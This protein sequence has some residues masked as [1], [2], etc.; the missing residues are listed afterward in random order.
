MGW[1]N[2]KFLKEIPKTDLHVHLDGSLRL[3][4]LIELAKEQ[5]VELPSYTE[6]G[7]RELVFKP[8]Y[9]NLDEYL[10]GFNY[11][12][13]VMRD[14]QSIQRISY[15]LAYDCFEEG[16]RYIEVRFAPQLLMNDLL[17]FED[18]VKAVDDGLR[19]ARSEINKLVKDDEPEFDYGIIIC[20]MRFCNEN[21]S[22][23][24]KQFFKMHKYTS[25]RDTIKLA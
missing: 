18:I 10:Q 25:L 2:E 4:T 23:Y 3:S 8:S 17:D 14:L 15:E 16:V 12:C 9:K 13:A 5:K 1:Y 22:P 20:A 24:Y 11:T 21:F 6:E 7:L 19:K